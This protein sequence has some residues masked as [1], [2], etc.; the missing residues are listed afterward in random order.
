MVNTFSLIE[1]EAAATDLSSGVHLTGSGVVQKR[2]LEAS[3]QTERNK[4]RPTKKCGEGPEE[5][6]K[7][8]WCDDGSGPG[9][10]AKFIDGSLQATE[11]TKNNP[12]PCTKGVVAWTM[13][14]TQDH[15][16]SP[17]GTLID[18]SGKVPHFLADSLIE[19]EAASTAA[20]VGDGSY[21]AERNKPRP[22]KKCGVGPT[23]A[24]KC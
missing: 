2:M 22:N 6:K 15:V 7:C 1:D 11:S 8:E 17:L 16:L 13:C 5:A 10:C 12:L 3:Y 21:Q 23:E 20:G 18:H 4:P 19:D 9:V 24:K 14:K